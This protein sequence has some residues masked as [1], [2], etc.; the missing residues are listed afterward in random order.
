MFYEIETSNMKNQFFCFLLISLFNSV[1]LSSQSTEKPLNNKFL[2]EFGI[3]YGGDEILQVFFT[4][5]EDQKM[6]AGQGLFIGFGGQFEI[7]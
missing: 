3:E 2:L 5:G 7:K 6:L 4:N 1:N